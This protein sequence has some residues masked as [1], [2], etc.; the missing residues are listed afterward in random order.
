LRHRVGISDDSSSESGGEEN[1]SSKGFS[2]GNKYQKGN[3]VQEQDQE[4][5]LRG[6]GV[7]D[8]DY[9]TAEDDEPKRPF[10][11]RSQKSRRRGKNM[12]RMNSPGGAQGRNDDLEMG[13][14]DT[15]TRQRSKAASFTTLGLEQVTPA[16][17]VLA[18]EGVED[19]L[20]ILDPAIMPLGIITLEDV[21]EELIGEEI[22]DEFDPHH[23]G[24]QLSSYIPPESD[25]D[26]EKNCPDSVSLPTMS[27]HPPLVT[28]EGE[29]RSLTTT[30]VLKPIASPALKGFNFLLHKNAPQAPKAPEWTEGVTGTKA[31]FVEPA[32]SGMHDTSGE[33]MVPSRV[34]LGDLSLPHTPPP[35]AL[36][37][38]ALADLPVRPEPALA[39][40][41]S[42]SEAAL[43][44]VF[45]TGNHSLPHNSRSTSPVP[46]L[47]AILLDRKRRG[48]ISSSNSGVA[49]GRVIAPNSNKGKFGF[50]SSPLGG[51]EQ[52]RLVIAEA[53]K[54]G[55]KVSDAVDDSG[56]GKKFML[57]DKNN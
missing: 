20:Q 4:A 32:A 11:L 38:S 54:K 17:A 26:H 56:Q 51:T 2:K 5:T 27:A 37:S 22:Y 3:K 36:P 31:L 28:N 15:D 9:D 33:F 25:E 48:V 21:L 43:A 57:D 24:A 14:I 47:E 39:K 29:S 53:V 46:S 35:P 44:P 23:Q 18:K 52:T 1:G 41:R 42:K 16:D 7:W 6:N 55:A 12:R 50:K 13:V 40:I 34:E 8:E 45:T 19:L 30:P 10:H 49:S